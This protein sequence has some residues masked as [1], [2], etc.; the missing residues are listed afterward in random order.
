MGIYARR[1]DDWFGIY[2]GFNCEFLNPMY[3]SI[4]EKEIREYVE[5]NPFANDDE[6]SL[7][8]FIGDMKSEGSF[9][10]P[11]HQRETAEWIA[12]AISNLV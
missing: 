1:V 8:D 5:T 10:I 11:T 2:D 6:Y 9:I 3:L 7:E 4:K 12:N